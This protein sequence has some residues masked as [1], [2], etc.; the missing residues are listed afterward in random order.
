MKISRLQTR[1]PFNGRKADTSDGPKRYEVSIFS[2][3][4]RIILLTID[5]RRLCRI[6]HI[7]PPRLLLWPGH[8]ARVA[9]VNILNRN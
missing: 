3:F 8:Q 7:L 9:N 1:D 5:P 6:K 4:P 2:H